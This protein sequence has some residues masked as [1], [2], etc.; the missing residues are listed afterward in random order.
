MTNIGPYKI[1]R[2]LGRGAMGVVYLAQDDQLG[3]QV[4]I[5]T[6]LLEP[7]LE[8]QQSADAHSRFLREARAAAALSHPHIITIYSI[9]EHEQQ[10]YIVMEFIDGPSLEFALTHDGGLKTGPVVAGLSQ[11][12]AALDYAHSRGIVHRDIKPANVLIS[13]SAGF[14]VA[15]FGIV[16]FLG[17]TGF[18]RT[19]GPVGTPYYISPEQVRGQKVSGRSDQFAL[20]V[21]AFRA[22]SG[23]LP[24]DGDSMATL[25]YRIVQEDPVD[26][27]QFNA[28][29]HPGVNAVLR[30]AM[31]KNPDERYVSCAEFT[32]ALD[33]AVRVPR[34]DRLSRD[35]AVLPPEPPP[36]EPPPERPPLPPPPPKPD[37][38]S[39]APLLV[40]ALMLALVVGGAAL[41]WSKIH[42]IPKP[43]PDQHERTIP[44]VDERERQS[45]PEKQADPKADQGQVDTEKVIKEALHQRDVAIKARDEIEGPD[46]EKVP[47]T[48]AP[49][50][51]ELKAG[52]LLYATSA[53]DAQK[54]VWI[55][56]GR[57]R[58]GCSIDDEICPADEKRHLVT[59]TRGFWLS[60]METTV[61]AYKRYVKAMV[62]K[63]PDTAV[64]RGNWN[65]D[66]MP[67]SNVS[68]LDAA[69]FCAWTG[70]RL[71]T[72]AEWEYA[73]RGGTLRH[74]YGRLKQIGWIYNEDLEIYARLHNGDY[75]HVG[76]KEPNRF[77]L[78]DMI[79]N[80]SEWTADRYDEHFYWRSS[81]TDPIGP[82]VSNGFVHRGGS[83]LANR[84]IRVSDRGQST[85]DRYTSPEIGFRC[86][87]GIAPPR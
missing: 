20:A 26:I 75:P 44:H 81:L 73:A 45:D 8:E 70:G 57:F 76:L 67:I 77:G 49:E 41:V 63:L 11:V 5:K 12:A 28:G 58:M 86:V 36:Q 42:P 85:D 43:V 72:E 4:A 68:H 6:I 29:L 2:E 62:A 79:G 16:K 7:G 87:G 39:W 56:P 78:Y 84:N 66:L 38:I 31:A 37:P 34:V 13:P 69:A 80:V 53:R 15:D 27:R 64:G 51:P 21:T 59:L 52:P 24:F 47:L 71:P 74:L 23:G 19:G 32:R 10:P 17:E 33:A 18:T 35:E 60:Q 1:V 22:L 46:R 61:G 48:D 65:D 50:V 30:K 83:M 14:K 82:D 40:L 55:Y 25:L 9:G 54:Y 3:R